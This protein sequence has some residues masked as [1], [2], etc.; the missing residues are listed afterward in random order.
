MKFL[1]L[2]TETTG[3][4]PRDQYDLIQLALLVEVDGTVVGEQIF[5][6]APFHPENV[7]DE[8]ISKHGITREMMAGFAPAKKVVW[9]EVVPFLD[10]F[11]NRFDRED[12][13]TPAAYNGHFDLEFLSQLFTRCGHKF[14][15]SYIDW[16]LQD[17]M[18]M[19]YLLHGWGDI[20]LS[21]YK[22]Q[23]VC[24]HFGVSLE[25]AHDAL[26][27]VRATRELYKVLTYIIRGGEEPHTGAQPA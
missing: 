21:N 6:L 16:R 5:H 9:E 13:M 18:G 24:D 15:G 11:C 20:R 2:D 22:L 23:T 7:T 10:R 27:D 8:S 17:V 26:N 25:G 3:V 12:K 1:Y 4:Y 19:A 14:L